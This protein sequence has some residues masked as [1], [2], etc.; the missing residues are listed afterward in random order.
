MTED[1]ERSGM[2]EEDLNAWR[3]RENDK[4]IEIIKRRANDGTG[5]G[6]VAFDH[7]VSK[8]INEGDSLNYNALSASEMELIGEG[9]F[10][11][12]MMF[13]PV[14]RAE[15]RKRPRRGTGAFSWATF[16][17]TEEYL[18]GFEHLR[19]KNLAEELKLPAMRE[20][21]A[22]QRPEGMLEQVRRLRDEF[23]STHAGKALARAIADAI[24][25]E[26]ER[27]GEMEPVSVK[28]VQNLLSEL[29]RI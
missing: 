28:R 9:F 4:Y 23:A 15:L 25:E 18:E 26:R 10:V 19:L 2:S 21:A 1:A 12:G 22:A 7:A 20:R 16:P 29:R 3:R 24:N 6:G 8:I 14:T 17:H 27:A 11:Q 13:G 5:R